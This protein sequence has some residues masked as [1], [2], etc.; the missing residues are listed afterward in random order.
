[1][2]IWLAGRGMEW[3]GKP[4]KKIERKFE[5]DRSNDRVFDLV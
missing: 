4:M 2:E 1:M 3:K 5:K